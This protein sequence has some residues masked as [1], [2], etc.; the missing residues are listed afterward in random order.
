M[1]RA[2]RAGT[3]RPPGGRGQNA[4]PSP[5][6]APAPVNGPLQIKVVY[7]KEASRAVLG[8]TQFVYA[9]PA[10]RSRAAT[11]HSFLVGRPGKYPAHRERDPG[12]GFPDRDLAR[13]AAA[14]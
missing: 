13:L 3:G 2:W 12:A 14:T 9:S 5:I 1:R 7:P 4:A 6:P 10:S 11:A 8:D